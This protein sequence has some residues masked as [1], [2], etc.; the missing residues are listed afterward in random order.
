MPGLYGITSNANVSVYNTTGLYNL[1]NANIILGNT[2]VSN[3]PGLY[4]GLGNP[5]ILT[6]AQVLYNLLS[7]SGNVQFALTAGNTLVQAFTAN[8]GTPAG[9]FGSNIAVAQ[10]TVT[11]DGRIQNIQ[12]VPIDFSTYAGNLS[13]D[14][15]TACNI[16]SSGNITAGEYFIGDGS[17]LTGLPPSTIFLVGDVTGTGNTGSNL[18]TTLSTTGVVGGL[19]GDDIRIPQITVDAKGRITAVANVVIAGGGSG[20][21][22]NANVAGYLPNYG[23]TINATDI[24]NTAQVNSSSNGFLQWQYTPGTLPANPYGLGDGSW[25][26][27]DDNGLTFDSNITGTPQNLTIDNNANVQT[28]GKFVT[29]LGVFWANGE[30]YGGTYSN[31]NVAAYLPTDPTIQAINANVTAANATAN[32]QIT[33][34]NAN[35]AAANA[36]IATL[37]T[38]V[39]SN[40]NV[41]AYLPINSANVAGQFFLGNAFYMTGVGAITYSNANVTAYLPLDPTITSMQSNIG[42]S[43]FFNLTTVVGTNWPTII[44]NTVA[45]LTYTIDA[46]GNTSIPNAL[47]I[48][49]LTT[50]NGYAVG[51][52]IVSV[53]NNTPSAGVFRITF[54]V[55]KSIYPWISDISTD[56]TGFPATPGWYSNVVIPTWSGNAT[57]QAYQINSLTSNVNILNSNI[58]ITSTYGNIAVIDTNRAQYV[59]SS[60][61]YFTY[62]IAATGNSWANS[63]TSINNLTTLNG[64]VVN[65][66]VT[67]VSY[68]VGPPNYYNYTFVIDR[69][70]YPW[71]SNTGPA[72]LPTT[73]AYSGWYANSR[74]AMTV[75]NATAQAN[76]IDS[77][78]SNIA[79]L[80]ANIGAFETYAN[81]TF[82]VSAGLYSN[83][84]V[85]AYL[86]TY[87]GSLG[88]SSSIVSIN[89]N[90][91]ASNANIGAYQVW[92]NANL[93]SST[94]SI[95]NIITNGF[96][97]TP[98]VASVGTNYPVL[99]STNPSYF[100]YT[101]DSSSAS[102]A[103]AFSAN[104]I[105][106]L[107]SGNGYPMTVQ[108]SNVQYVAGPP[109]RYTLTFVVN[110]SAYPWYSSSGP[111][112]FPAIGAYAN[113]IVNGLTDFS[114][115]VSA[116]LTAYQAYANSAIN[117]TNAN[118]AAANSAISSTNANV[119]AANSAISVLQTN[120]ATQATQINTINANV[121]AAN[122]VIANLVATTYSNANVASYLPVYGGNIFVSNITGANV[123]F[124]ALSVGFGSNAY[125][126]NG[127]AQ[128]GGVSLTDSIV[129]APK[130]VDAGN[131]VVAYDAR[132]DNGNLVVQNGNIIAVKFTPDVG[133]FIGDGS[134]LTNINAGNIV[135]SYGNANV[136][137]Y[138]PTDP[139]ITAIQANVTAA[140]SAIATLDANVGAY[141][142]WANGRITTLDANLGT[143]TTNITTLFA[144]AATQAIDINLINANV[145]AVNVEIANLKTTTYSNA[146]VAAYLPLYGGDLNP[147]NVVVAGNLTVNGTTTS[148][149]YNE[150]VAGLLVANSTTAATS[151]TSGALQVKGGAGVVGNVVA[152]AFYSDYHLYA[153]G[154]PYAGTY[155]NANARASISVTSNSGVYSDSSVSYNPTTGVITYNEPTWVEHS[156]NI[157]LPVKNTSGG[158]LA[159][160][161][162]VYATGTVGATDVLE[163]SAS[164]ADTSSTLP[165]IGLLESAL[166]NNATGYVVQIGFLNN[167][168]TGSYAIDDRLYVGATGGL[169]NVRPADGNAVQFL[170]TVV[171]AQASTGIIS[172][173]IWDIYDLPNLGQGNIWVGPN[174]G[175]Q[176]QQVSFQS[177][178]SANTVITSINANITAANA[179]IA[180]LDANIGAYETWA[181][182]YFGTSNY[183]N[184]N[185][186][187]Y[188]P[189]DPTITSIEANVTA[190]NAHIATL[191]A[192]VGAYETWA[193]G[194]ITTLDAN[195]GTLTT[196]VD[197]LDANVGAY[198]A[199]ANASIA[200]TNANVTAA[201][202]AISTNLT[203]LVTLEGNVGAF[204]TYANATFGTKSELVNGSYT[205]SLNSDGTVTI[206]TS[207][208]TGTPARL[209]SIGSNVQVNAN[210]AIYE[211]QQNGTFV[212]PYS[213][214]LV[215]TG[216]KFPDNTVQTTAYTGA[217]YGNTQVA[218][219]LP[220]DS[221]IIAIEANV[222]AANAHIATIDANV[223]AYETWA[224]GY[225]ASTSS[226]STYTPLSTFN[227]LDANVGAF[228]TYANTTFATTSQLSAYTLQ[229]TF[230]VLD[231]NVGAYETWANGRIT[232]LDANLGTLTT[233]VD[234]L[235]ANL[236]AFETYANA[237]F[238]SS[239]YG[240]ANVA[241]YLPTDPTITAIQANVTAANSSIQT[242]SANL[243]AFETYANA[244]FGSSSYGN[245]QVAAYLPTDPTIQSIQA[246]IGAYETWANGR[247]ATLDA[248]LGTATTNITT[249]FSNAATQ[250]TAIDTLN[251]N[252]GA[253][254]TYANS[255]FYKSG[256]TITVA[257]VITT[258]GV[259]WSN[260]AAYSTG[261][262]TYGNT[263]VAAY[264]PVYAGNISAANMYATSANVTGLMFFGSSYKETVY[265]F[266]TTSGTLTVNVAN[267]TIQ[268]VTVN[269]NITINTNNFTNMGPGQSVTVVIRQ[270]ATGG[271]TLTSNVLFAGNAKTLTNAASAV[272]TLSVFYDGTS[273]LG[274]LVKGYV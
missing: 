110:R 52:N 1:S 204:E 243:G 223:G 237:T 261:G 77:I 175:G 189:T 32:S 245:T 254:Q 95:N 13:V 227:V 88:N 183:S 220:T 82:V 247:I 62:T 143:A 184:V 244:T 124:D 147:G 260:G 134:K 146:N 87:T 104:N 102:N 3:T 130:R 242:L 37:Q 258:A 138:L 18:T 186:A 90:I 274:A 148:I 180:T 271:R 196:R 126:G 270:D 164:R 20:T 76:A 109:Q 61:A 246:N 92:S 238:G 57:T 42:Q 182:S 74:V 264:L 166:A 10:L 266:G 195:L 198:E 158:T 39:Y 240:N 161:T 267:G 96:Y 121:A 115:N 160:G 91:A 75:S 98:N 218:A 94:V 17:L 142:T 213:V 132:I 30:I 103:L 41:T 99:V 125:V 250:A 170:G 265:A 217:T 15:L 107:T 27:L 210:G 174:G 236:G 72:S 252:V 48:N 28:T 127:G 84:N 45:N 46:T 85:A 89:S 26:Y 34:T 38:Q 228:E 140:N 78:N 86:P 118:V 122:L 4:Q 117:A 224:N 191:D 16:V 101:I 136:A 60:T 178:L 188:L 193:N 150:Y 31:A 162:P 157:R 112:S 154:Q 208:V 177:Y 185:V 139:T 231:A 151:T 111:T 65:G 156:K 12:N 197:T 225:F 251:A 187:A 59:A 263:Q 105:T 129:T 22:G 209:Q 249:L 233:H 2:S 200:S 135:G 35:V 229:T 169:T 33:S 53:A 241:A 44:A 255:T 181:N 43:T 203:R 179:H 216:I 8:I 54:N 24:F 70:L 69:S 120:A 152:G 66:N 73:V 272:D 25:L 232:T 257:N 214:A 149:N 7:E 211:F 55:R 137:A 14:Q 190:A 68:V 163:V 80:D 71:V 5:T 64:N 205:L 159:V 97:A 256:S 11:G 23:G 215:P 81:A 176:P 40:A 19:Y 226:L 202:S 63:A 262:G 131:L 56:P 201:N 29:T 67:A 114:S 192:N 212:T 51:G 235:D 6:N 133:Y 79:I 106:N 269:G 50:G 113:S 119:T 21:Y 108:I 100:T 222:T 219:Y 206:P 9:T 168:D 234:T 165:V 207:G 171:R 248:N 239:S 49:N 83:V 123:T 194:R 141:E 153:N 172:V 128:F 116:N 259:Y 93:I 155:T 58:G 47:A 199:W 230:N 253:Y 36:A 144:N 221:T 273:Y 268:T 167:Q 173:D 145:T